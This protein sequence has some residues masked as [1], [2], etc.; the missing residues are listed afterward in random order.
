MDLHEQA[1]SAERTGEWGTAISLVS[2]RAACSSTDFSAH[3][4]HLWHMG[5]LVRA[6]R[7]GQLAKPALTDVHSGPPKPVDLCRVRA[8]C[9]QRRGP[10]GCCRTLESGV[11]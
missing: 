10:W 9:L 3:D 7:F 11:T 1:Q 6:E 4:N 2:A 8:K 5:L